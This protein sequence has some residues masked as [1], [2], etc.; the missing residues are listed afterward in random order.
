VSS[1]TYLIALYTDRLN[2]VRLVSSFVRRIAKICDCGTLRRDYRTESH[3]SLARIVVYRLRHYLLENCQLEYCQRDYY[4]L[5]ACD[6]R[7]FAV[8]EYGEISEWNYSCI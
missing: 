3:N 1:P 4:L 6:L 8:L 5:I 7:G 2:G